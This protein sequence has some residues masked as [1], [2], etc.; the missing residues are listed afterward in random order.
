MMEYSLIKEKVYWLECSIENKNLE[1]NILNSWLKVGKSVKKEK[2][3]CD[4]EI[5]EKLLSIKTSFNKID[6]TEFEYARSICNPFEKIGRSIFQN[7][8]AVKI[9]NL[10]VIF[11]QMFT[12]PKSE[13][14]DSMVKDQL[15][16]A[17]VCGGPGGFSEYILWRL[18][19]KAKGFGFTLRNYLDFKLHLLSHKKEIFDAFYGVRQDGN[20]MNPENIKSLHRYVLRQTN[21]TGV[22]Y[23]MADGGFFVDEKNMQEFGSKQLYLCQCITALL[24]VRDGGSC[25]I[26][27]F[28]LF[29][30]FSV[31]LIYLMHKCFNKICIIK[32]NSSRPGNS[33]RYVI[34]KYKRSQIV[35]IVE[36]LFNI[37]EQ[38]WYD[39]GIDILQIVPFEIINEDRNFYKYIVKSNNAIGTRQ[40]KHL[41]HID[42]YIEC[43]I[44]P[45]TEEQREA[46]KICCLHEWNLP[47]KQRI[48]VRHWNLFIKF[49]QIRVKL[50]C[51][52]VSFHPSLPFIFVF[53]NSK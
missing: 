11:D 33:E 16:F 31:G 43:G 21:E 44:V 5:I 51:F 2:R 50:Q 46:F 35:T 47:N 18:N 32:P 6:E 26:K 19:E 15:F 14:G 23:V 40:I 25:V 24:L 42:R 53:C 41:S 36:Y 3:F 1:R 30:L 28:D 4:K 45:F 38:L 7:R 49:S 22:H 8:A 13:N 52:L 37:N 39:R 29:D 34:C 12:K 27:F 9:V 17:D 10:D 20:I 48:K